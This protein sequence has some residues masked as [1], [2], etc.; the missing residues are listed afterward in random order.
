MLRKSCCPHSRGTTC[1]HLLLL[2]HCDSDGAADTS[3]VDHAERQ[4][5]RSCC[6]FCLFVFCDK[7]CI[8]KHHGY[9][10]DYPL[11]LVECQGHREE[12]RRCSGSMSNVFARFPASKDHEA[13]YER[14]SGRGIIS[15]CCQI[16]PFVSYVCMIGPQ[17]AGCCDISNWLTMQYGGI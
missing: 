3:D 5:C 6:F 15:P 12:L 7:S 17:R 14:C 13:Y 16:S 2:R 8:S 10:T 4:T 9:V 1:L 11:V